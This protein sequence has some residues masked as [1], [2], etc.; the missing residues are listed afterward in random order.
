MRAQREEDQVTN[1]YDKPRQTPANNVPLTPLQFLE[2]AAYVY[3][4]RTA[5]IHG[6]RR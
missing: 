6:A 3:P 5:M 1:P 4:N 2:R